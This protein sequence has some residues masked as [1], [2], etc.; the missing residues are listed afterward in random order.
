M[1]KIRPAERFIEAEISRSQ[2]VPRAF[3]GDPTDP[4]VFESSI[5]IGDDLDVSASPLS[6]TLES[7]AP[8]SR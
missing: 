5:A 7:L 6:I 3:D 2:I 4:I 1:L 8:I